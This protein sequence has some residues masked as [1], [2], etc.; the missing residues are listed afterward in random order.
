MEIEDLVE[1]VRAGESIIVLITLRRD[2]ILG[3][4]RRAGQFLGKVKV[5]CFD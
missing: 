2:A 4:T 1:R 5:C 3:R